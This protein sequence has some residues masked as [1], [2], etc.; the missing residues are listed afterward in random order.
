MIH[1][2]VFQVIYYHGGINRILNGGPY[3][4]KTHCSLWHELCDLPRFSPWK[5]RCDGCWSPERKCNKNCAIRS[6]IHLKG[7]FCFDCNSFPCKRLLKLDSRYKKNYRMSMIENLTAIK[8]QGI[9]KFLLTEKK[10]WTCQKCGG[11]ICVHR[12]FCYTCG[13]KQ[14]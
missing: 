12:G 7:K 13:E 14:E 2:G 11:I 6:C 3:E 1:P 5:N 10:R 4:G 9:R 8:I